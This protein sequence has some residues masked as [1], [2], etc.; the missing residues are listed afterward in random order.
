M[1]DPIYVTTRAANVTIRLIFLTIIPMGLV[2]LIF[3][4]L[5]AEWATGA[6]TAG[7]IFLTVVCVV[8]VGLALLRVMTF[9]VSR[10]PIE[11]YPDRIV[12]AGLVKSTFATANITGRGVHARR[13]DV[14]LDYRDPEKDQKGQIPLPWKFIA[15]PAEEVIEQLDRAIAA[16]R[17][18]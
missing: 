4:D 16:A 3:S 7:T 14:C 5:A 15:E 8:L 10:R 17:A 18:S 1:S 2:A 9:M 6:P 12:V 13:G 11:I